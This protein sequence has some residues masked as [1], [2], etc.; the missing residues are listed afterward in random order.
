MKS[1]GATRTRGSQLA[2]PVSKKDHLAGDL[3]APLVLVE[4]GDFECTHCGDAYEMIKDVQKEFEDKLL[5]VFRHFPLADHHPHA[6]HAAEAAEA[7]A[8]QGYFWAMHDILFENQEALADENLAGYAAAIG[9]SPAQLLADLNSRT[10]AQ[11]VLADLKGGVESGVD[12]TPCF[13]INGV[14]YEGESDA[15][16]LIVEL[17]R[18]LE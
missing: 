18:Q 6:E 11:Q 13:F 5:F 17:E 1:K 7:A 2:I 8:A 9:I 4:Y 15:Q 12:G 14:P 16:T 3:S 10:F